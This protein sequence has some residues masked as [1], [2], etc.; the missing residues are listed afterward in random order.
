MD[1][2]EYTAVQMKSATCC[3]FFP[4]DA[5]TIKYEVIVRKDVHVHCSRPP[6]RAFH[7]AQKG[8]ATET[9]M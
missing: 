6:P 3:V 5:L 7:T 8:R 4:S 2:L 1:A 9:L